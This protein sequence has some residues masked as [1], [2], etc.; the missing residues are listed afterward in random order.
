MLSF[1]VHVCLA[2]TPPPTG[3]PPLWQASGGVEVE[4]QL[5]APLIPVLLC[6]THPFT[7]QDSRYQHKLP[8]HRILSGPGDEENLENPELLAQSRR[9]IPKQRCHFKE[10]STNPFFWKSCL[11]CC[12]TIP[13]WL[14]LTSW[15]QFT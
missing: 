2:L 13:S 8:S 7:H 4:G 12:G 6:A 11:W 9:G 5:C 3:V 15:E 1:F 14:Y 10:K